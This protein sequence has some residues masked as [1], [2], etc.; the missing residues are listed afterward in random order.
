MIEGVRMGVTMLRL[1]VANPASPEITETVEF[2]IDSGAL[3]SLVPRPVLQRVGINPL[4]VQA[5][6]LANGQS[7]ERQIGV[8]LF[9]YRDRVGG[10]TVI[11]GEAEDSTLLGAYTLESMGFSLDP[12]RHELVPLP[13]TLA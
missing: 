3:Y 11:F 9:K 13:M 12:V 7:I 4:R 5:F 6:R 2:L 1:E 10:A 8:A